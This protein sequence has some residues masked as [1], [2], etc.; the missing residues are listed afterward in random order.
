MHRKLNRKSETMAVNPRALV[1]RRLYKSM[2]S[3]ALR[4]D[5]QPAL[6]V[7]NT[8]RRCLPPA[9][10]HANVSVLACLQTLI[11]PE[12]F[13]YGY[14]L[15]RFV[16]PGRRVFY[17]PTGTTLSDILRTAFRDPAA[18]LEATSP[19]TEQEKESG[20]YVS[21][22]RAAEVCTRLGGHNVGG[23]LGTYYGLGW[24]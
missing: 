24:T 20:L 2:L 14:G 10:V 17:L 12:V 9:Q 8:S 11:T 3:L 6:K 13:Q 19:P 4:F 5:A 7:R 21:P 1:A 16:L 22:D 23:L 18:F 15:W